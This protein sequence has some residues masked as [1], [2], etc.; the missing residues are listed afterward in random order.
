M[1][2][3]MVIEGDGVLRCI[4]NGRNN[5]LVTMND[6]QLLKEYVWPSVNL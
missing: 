1:T 5:P 2:D 4:F 3:F 6:T